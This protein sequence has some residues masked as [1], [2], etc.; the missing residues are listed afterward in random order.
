M[1]AQVSWEEVKNEMVGE[2]GLAPEVAD[3]IGVYVQQHGKEQTVPSKP[4][5]A[6]SVEAYVCGGECG[7]GEECMYVVYMR[8]RLERGVF[9]GEK[10]R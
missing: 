1:S 7:R 6:L 8:E 9:E 10:G 3:S 2:K 4:C 5:P